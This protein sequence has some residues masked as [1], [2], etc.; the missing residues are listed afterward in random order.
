M[1]GEGGEVGGGAFVDLAVVPVGLAEGV[2]RGRRA[3]EEVICNIWLARSSFPDPISGHRSA[4]APVRRLA[5]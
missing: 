4:Q 3:K 1:L 2:A 5:K